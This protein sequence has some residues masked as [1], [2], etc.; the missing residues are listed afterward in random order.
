M[1]FQER[2]DWW[3]VAS[4]IDRQA[5]PDEVIMTGGFL[6][7]ELLTYHMADDADRIFIHNVL[8]IDRL[9][10]HV[11][12]ANV[13]WFINAAPLPE[14]YRKICRKYLPYRAAVPGNGP[15][16]VIQIFAKRPFLL[17]DGRP[18]PYYKPVPLAYENPQVG[19]GA[20]EDESPA[21]ARE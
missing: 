15:S 18:A 2:P 1:F 20:V 11:R 16:S 17:P 8:D 9:Y 13:I 4:I 19:Q 14:A 12:M 5:T 6:S 10:Q 21:P 7:G 3:S